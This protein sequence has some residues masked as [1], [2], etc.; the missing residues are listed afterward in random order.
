MRI[1]APHYGTQTSK[2]MWVL[3]FWT[4]FRMPLLIFG[5]GFWHP[6]EVLP[7]QCMEELNLSNT[8]NV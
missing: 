8:S 3:F 2:I 6:G 1:R 4:L 7:V 5:Q